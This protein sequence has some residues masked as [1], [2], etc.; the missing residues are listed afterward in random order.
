MSLVKLFLYQHNYLEPFWF[1]ILKLKRTLTYSPC[2]S[3]DSGTYESLYLMIW[4]EVHIHIKGHRIYF[5]GGIILGMDDIRCV[6]RFVAMSFSQP[7]SS[8]S[9]SSSYPYF[10]WVERDIVLH[11][12]LHL[13]RHQCYSPTTIYFFVHTIVDT[14]L[15][16]IQLAK[17]VTER[18]HPI[19]TLDGFSNPHKKSFVSFT[20]RTKPRGFL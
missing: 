2:S 14:D 1:L 4:M 18:K 11:I 7:Q 10:Y 6:W 19:R 8:Y 5:V 16:T 15:A 13:P 12:Y 17:I 3:S 20:K 9:L